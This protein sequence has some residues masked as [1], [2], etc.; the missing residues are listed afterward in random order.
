MN[1]IKLKDGTRI[2]PE[3]ITYY[4]PCNVS[5]FPEV[6]SKIFLFRQAWLCSEETPEELDE[7]FRNFVP[8]EQ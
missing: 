8:K 3:Y 1:I 5:G 2:N 4:I 6:K 7:I